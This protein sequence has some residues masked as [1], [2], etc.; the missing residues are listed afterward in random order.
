MAVRSKEVIGEHSGSVVDGDR[1]LAS[2]KN[3]GTILESPKNMEILPLS[4]NDE[5]LA[6][7][8]QNTLLQEQLE[9]IDYELSKFD[10][11]KVKGVDFDNSELKFDGCFTVPSNGRGGGLALLWKEEDVVW[12]DSFSH[13]HIDAVV[14]E[15]V[16]AWRLIGFYGESEMSRRTEG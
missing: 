1:R 7:T 13:Y 6:K 5:I 11:V 14:Q 12:V 3:Q 2:P 4:R 16:N 8:M 10:N 9:E 15:G